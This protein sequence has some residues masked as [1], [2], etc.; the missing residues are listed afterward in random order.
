MESRRRAI[1]MAIFYPFTMALIATGFIAF[2]MLILEVPLPVVSAVVL[3]FYSACAVSIYLIFRP[4]IRDLRARRP[5]L[6][7][8]L[9]MSAFAIVS[10]VLV[11]WEWLG[12]RL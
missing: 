4:V 1:L 2:I 5:L 3:S 12:G 11:V 7:F 9:T 8:V 6:G 10:V